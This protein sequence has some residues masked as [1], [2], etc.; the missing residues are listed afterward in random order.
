MTNAQTMPMISVPANVKAEVEVFAETG[1]QA[2]SADANR[3]S[4]R[5]RFKWLLAVL[6]KRAHYP[7]PPQAAPPPSLMPPAAVQLPPIDIKSMIGKE[8]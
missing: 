8:K 2:S 6:F 5:R 4:T 7:M 3:K 1:G